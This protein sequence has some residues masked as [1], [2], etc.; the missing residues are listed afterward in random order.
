M[1]GRMAAILAQLASY[2]SGALEIF[3][4]RNEAKNALGNKFN[5]KI[6]HH[7]ILKSGEVPL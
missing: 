3:A 4:L 1:M 7:I 6:F 2:D 5:L